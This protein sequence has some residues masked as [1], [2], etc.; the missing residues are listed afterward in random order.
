MDGRLRFH[1]PE[2]GYRIAIDPI[3]LAAAVPVRPGDKVLDAGVG[4][5]AAMLC[6]AAREP[7]CR[8]V[9]IEVQRELL[10]IAKLNIAANGLEHQTEVIAGDLSRPPPRLSAASFDH[11]MTNPPFLRPDVHAAPPNKQR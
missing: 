4:T 10:R 9:G 5:G 3:F 6:L 7:G 1:Q 2:S 8:I 11:V